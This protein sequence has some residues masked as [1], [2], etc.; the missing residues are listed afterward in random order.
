MNTTYMTYV[1]QYI[2]RL[3]Y[4]LIQTDL[5]IEYFLFQKLHVSQMLRYFR[6]MI[7]FTANNIFIL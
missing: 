4:C 2:A 3:Q 6:V 7:S 5:V 1:I